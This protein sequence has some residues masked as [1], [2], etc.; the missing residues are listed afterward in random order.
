M[1]RLLISTEFMHMN[2]ELLKAIL[3]TYT[4]LIAEVNALKA[5]LSE[6]GKVLADS[7]RTAVA[8]EINKMLKD[9]HPN[10]TVERSKGP[11]DGQQ[12]SQSRIAVQSALVEPI[13]LRQQWSAVTSGLSELQE[14]KQPE[15]P[16]QTAT[17]CTPTARKVPSKNKP[18]DLDFSATQSCVQKSSRTISLTQ[19]KKI[20]KAAKSTV[21]QKSSSAIAFGSA[22]QPRAIP[23]VVRPVSE[24]K[25]S[26]FKM[27]ELELCEFN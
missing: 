4:K 3:G 21:A 10:C 15:A 23:A 9:L 7:V 13:L 11:A 25:S 19:P 18:Y 6:E 22:S 24:A 16:P 1:H 20:M 12:S 2:E 5:Q 27:L 8:A 17:Q 14:A 26:F